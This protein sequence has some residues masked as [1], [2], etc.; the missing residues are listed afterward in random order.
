MLKIF[1]SSTFRDLEDIRGEILKQLNSAFKGVG[2]EEFIPDGSKSQEVCIENLK[3]RKDNGIVIFLISPYYG[4]LMGSCSLKADCK[5]DCPMKT[6]KGRISYTHCE[7]KTTIAEG[8]LHQTYLIEQGWED[9]QIKEEARAFKKEIELG[10]FRYGIQDSEDSKLVPLICNNLATKIMEWYSE[11]KLEFPDFCDRA[12]ELKK[13]LDNIDEPLEIY[14]VGGIGKTI[15]AQIALLIQRLRGKEIIAI[16]IERSFS[17]ESGH[18]DFREKFKTFQH[19]AKLKKI[20]IYDILDSLSHLLLDI[21]E[22]KNKSKNE[23]IEIIQNF[24]KNEENLILFIDDFHNADE[25]VQK[26][27]ENVSRIIV[28]SRK[29]TGLTRKELCIVGIREE[30]RPDFINLLCGRH[31]K[32][33]SEEAKET[34]LKITEGHP[35]F[36]ELLVRNSEFI[37]FSKIKEFD[38]K[39]DLKN[40]NSIQVKKFLNRVV[41]E[42]LSDKAFDLLKD[43]ST[44]DVNLESNIERESVEASFDISE[45]NECFNELISTG[46]IKKKE[47]KEGLYEFSYKYIQNI[48]EEMTDKGRHEKAIKY[49]KKKEELIGENINDSVEILYHKVR[50]NPT[51]ELVNEVLKTKE[52]LKPSHYGFKRLIDVGEELKVFVEEENKVHIHEV[53][54]A[55]YLDLGWFDEAENSYLGAIKIIKDLV[56]QSPETYLPRVAAIQSRLGNLYQILRRFK[57]SETIFLDV[58]DIY[59]MLAKQ[60]SEKYLSQVANTQ[61]NLGVSYWSLKR[62]EEAEKI[63]L[64]ALQI[65]RDLAVQNPEKYLHDIAK[66]QINLGALYKSRGRREE[67]ENSYREALQISKDLAMQYPEDNLL[68]ISTTQ[69]NLGNLYIDLERYEEAEEAYLEALEIKKDMVKKNPEKYSLGVAI[70]LHNLGDLYRNIDRFSDSENANI[71]ALRILK[72][73]AEQSPEAYLP[74]VSRSQ[75]NLGDLYRDIGRVEEAE[76]AYSEALKIRKEL[77]KQKPGVNLPHVNRIQKILG[78]FY[79]DRKKFEEAEVIFLDA[80]TI[81]KKLAKLSPETYLPDVGMIQVTL[82]VLY[83]NLSMNKKVESMFLGALNVFKTL[84]EQ[85]PKVY[86]PQVAST[87]FDLGLLYNKLD[88]SKKA[89]EIFLDALNIYKKLAEENP[90]KFLPKVAN[91]QNALSNLYIKLGRVEDLEVM[92][93]NV[94]NVYKKLVEQN[95]DEYLPQV[96]YTQN[97]LINLYNNLGRTEALEEMFLD[98]LNVYNKLAEQNPKEFLPQIANTQNNLINLYE[99]LG[100]TEDLK[101]MYLDLLNIYKKLVEQNPEEYLSNVGDTQH[102]LGGLYTNLEQYDD[103]KSVYQEALNIRKELAAKDPDTHLASVAATQNNLGVSF[104]NLERFNDAES[105]Y[106]EAL[107]IRKELAITNPEVHLPKVAIVY[108]N[109][110]CLESVMNNKDNS[111]EFLKKAI[112]L[113]RTFIDDA[114]TDEEFDRIRNFKA[115]KEVIGEYPIT[116]SKQNFC[117]KCGTKIKKGNKYCPKCGKKL[118]D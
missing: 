37:N 8:I 20:S 18:K 1:L 78:S 74:I 101:E 48:L 57:P 61:N 28:S 100:R 53:L 71:E 94:L 97:N 87:Q 17:N 70:T 117:T 39:N 84:A 60:N 104:A 35:I 25:D 59:K 115:F 112:E 99:K 26:L 50:S 88:N 72:G 56:G 6:G 63:Y 86:L 51:E 67:A 34:I 14:G 5:A 3:K 77:V 93:Q 62:Y 44:L 32:N 2:M 11:N 91:T 111:I 4:S 109:K 118:I 13:I 113:D 102:N 79:L 103:A 66:T 40:V 89:E 33:L 64:E 29:T 47:G 73:F 46:M 36:T 95:P 54:G 114:K 43:L 42:I 108:Y 92:F 107:N 38:L 110:A 55:L 49:Y 12:G 106:Q 23:I 82:G 52:K 96:A 7:Y 116:E 19:E 9:P 58:L 31:I 98:L 10:E 69:S 83:R 65:T 21:E 27:V 85:N 24:I 81:N 22:V 15:L 30:D 90:E 80:L 75:V 76:N 16:G 41:E 105:A 68:F 45:V